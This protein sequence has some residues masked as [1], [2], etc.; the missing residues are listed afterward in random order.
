MVGRSSELSDSE[1][2]NGQDQSGAKTLLQLF[3]PRGIL[4]EISKSLAAASP[5]HSG[6]HAFGAHEARA[7]CGGGRAD[8]SLIRRRDPS[9]HVLRDAR[10][11]CITVPKALTLRQ[12]SRPLRYAKDPSGGGAVRALAARLVLG[13]FSRKE[14]DDGSQNYHLENRGRCDHRQGSHGW[15]QAQGTIGTHG[16]QRR[17]QC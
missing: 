5:A 11:V 4:P 13:A 17:T 1:G 7:D 15:P 2:L 6:D 3:S 8:R 9:T 10:K 16:H 14:H 12:L